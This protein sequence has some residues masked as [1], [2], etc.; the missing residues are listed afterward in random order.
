RRPKAADEQV[1]R[2]R[3]V[4]DALYEKKEGLEE[5]MSYA[6]E[7]EYHRKEIEKIEREQEWQREFYERQRKEAAL[8]KAEVMNCIF[9]PE[10]GVAVLA[11]AFSEEI[12]NDWYLRMLVID[13]DPS[14]EF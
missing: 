8:H 14:I 7:A 9:G 5:L 3:D 11:R 2:I 6:V 1:S 12:K 13:V 4:Q 10:A